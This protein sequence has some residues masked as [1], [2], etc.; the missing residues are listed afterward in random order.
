MRT[1][2]ID[3]PDLPAYFMA[4]TPVEQLGSLNGRF[5]RRFGEGGVL[6]DQQC[7]PAQC[8]R[9]TGPRA[10]PDRD[11]GGAH[12]RAIQAER[13]FQ[14]ARVDAALLEP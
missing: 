13:T 11:Q 1:P 14:C 4:S 9:Q 5:P 7:D 3:D 2:D 12:G 8:E 6:A 10:G